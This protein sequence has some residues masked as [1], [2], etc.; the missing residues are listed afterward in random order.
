M[1]KRCFMAE[2]G[3]FL[4]TV[5]LMCFLT[6]CGNDGKNKTET[7]EEDGTEVVPVG[8]DIEYQ[9]YELKLLTQEEVKMAEELVGR[10]GKLAINGKAAAIEINQIVQ[11]ETEGF[12]AGDKTAGEAADIVQS[13]VGIYVSENS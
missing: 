4:L 12:F 8:T 6:S 7:A 13:R 3:I 10:V 11:E 9:G 1:R 5:L 2:I